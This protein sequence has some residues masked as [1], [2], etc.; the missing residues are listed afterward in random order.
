MTLDSQDRPVIAYYDETN[1]NVKVLKCGNADCSSGNEFASAVKTGNVGSSISIALDAN[2]IPTISFRD[3]D[4]LTLKI[5]R[6]GN[7]ACTSNENI[8]STPDPSTNSVGAFTSLALDSRGYPI[9]SYL[10]MTDTDLKV[11]SCGDPA[12]ASSGNV[13]TTPDFADL[14]GSYSSLV[15]DAEGN[16]VISYRDVTNYDLKVIHCGNPSCTQGNVISSPDLEGDV[17]RF[18]SM[19]L[20]DSG[21]PVIAYHDNTSGNL[22]VIHCRNEFCSS[23]NNVIVVADSD[24]DLGEHASLA[25]NDQGHPVVSYSDRLNGRLKVL[26]CGNP[27]CTSGN[28]ITSHDETGVLAGITDTSL[29]LIGNKPVVSYYDSTEKVLKLLTC[30]SSTCE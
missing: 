21:F 24:G 16:P 14:V 13:I 8:L 2:D 23:T 6:C 27:D 28:V 12:C 5:L 18:T 30:S 9:L 19:Q 1:G 10:D 20:D 11:L 17:G 25:L 7:E 29:V 22:K 15:L 3:R 4:L 26:V